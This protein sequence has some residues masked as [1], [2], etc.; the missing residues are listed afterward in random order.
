MADRPIIFSGAMVRALV[1]G[2]K[3]QTRR[4]ASSPLARCTIGD[5]LYVRESAW[6]AP[7]GWTDSPVNPMGPHRREVAYLADDRSGYT[8]AAAADYKLKLRP[9]I[10][11]PRWASR[12]TLI[13]E[14]VRFEPL[15]AISW[16]DAVCEGCAGR[17]GPNPEFPDE[18][19]PSPPEEYRDLWQSLHDKPGQRWEDNPDVLV[20]TFR[21][22]RANIDRL[23]A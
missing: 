1:D 16:N 2:R 17:R 23:P 11:M 13:V 20:L 3:T 22:E 6:I 8:R 12:L 19:D 18:W 21:V 14:G 7:A 9:S 4:L 10:H 15:Q 5:R